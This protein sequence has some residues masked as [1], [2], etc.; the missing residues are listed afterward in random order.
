VGDAGTDAAPRSLTI[1]AYASLIP[2]NPPGR[3]IPGRSAHPR[4]VT[5][6]LRSAHHKTHRVVAK[7][8]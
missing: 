3:R 4:G 5:G 8:V 2:G 7:P 1:A 6:V